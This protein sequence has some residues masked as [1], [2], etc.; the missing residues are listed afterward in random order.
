MARAEDCRGARLSRSM[1]AFHQML[2]GEDLVEPLA[3]GHAQAGIAGQ[4]RREQLGDA[5]AERGVVGGA[6]ERSASEVRD[7]N[8]RPRVGRGLRAR[9]RRGC[10]GNADNGVAQTDEHD[11]K[12]RLR[13]RPSQGHASQGASG[14]LTLLLY[15]Y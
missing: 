11:G 12:M 5:A 6:G 15:H 3:F 4:R 13:S 9:E 1:A 10:D 7:G 2:L 14:L 8:G